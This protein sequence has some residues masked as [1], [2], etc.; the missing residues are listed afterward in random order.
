M[1]KEDINQYTLRISQ[2]N[3]SQYVVIVYDIILQLLEEM[4]I[5]K[6]NE[7]MEEYQHDLQKIKVL[8]QELI[9]GMNMEDATGREVVSLYLYVHKILVQAAFH[10]EQ[11]DL[12]EVQQIMEKLKVGFE[13]LTKVDNDGPMMQNTEKVYAGLTYGKGCLNEVKMNSSE[14]RGFTV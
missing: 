13:H 11:A 14:S 10:P 8:L 4:N 2:A 6:Q 12:A 3:H 5:A 7:R 1:T 9:Q